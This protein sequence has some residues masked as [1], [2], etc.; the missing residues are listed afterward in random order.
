MTAMKKKPLLRFAIVCVLMLSTSVI[1][2]SVDAGHSG[3]GAGLGRPLPP[4]WVPAVD[5]R[6]INMF[7]SLQLAEFRTGDAPDS[8]AVDSEG[9]IGGDYQR[10]WWKAQGDG[11]TEG[12]KPGEFEV[13]G[14]YSRLFAP[15]WDL[16]TGLRVDRQF[17]RLTRK[18][19]GFFVIGLEGLAPYWFEVEPALFLSE[20]G[21][22]SFQFTGSYDQLI[23]QR[24]VIQPRIDLNAALQDD[25]RRNVAAG[26]NDIELSLRL[27]YDIKRQ[28][29][30]YI[31]VTWRRVLGATASLARGA[32]KDLSATSVAFGLRAWY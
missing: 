16:Q 6:M 28:F 26:F 32:G 20:K 1:A 8:I 2:Q 5:D 31:G 18:T 19:T 14:L 9:W 10:F 25:R 23:T 15:F 7:T 27:R 29:S 21:K 30:P 11:E 12:T 24:L 17:S 3:H 22:A 4:G 13:Q